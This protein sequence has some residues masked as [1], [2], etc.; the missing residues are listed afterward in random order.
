MGAKDWM[1]VYAG[2]EVRPILRAVPTLDRDATRAL[3]ARLYPDA[4]IVDLG[5]GDLG[6]NANPTGGEVYAG[7]FPGLTI[8]CTPD[9]GLDHPSTLD[10]RFRAEARGRTLYLHAMHSVV[11]WFAYA[12]WAPDGEL[13]RSLSLSPESGILE[14]VGAPLAFEAPYWAGE[15]AVDP[16]DSGYPLPFHPLELAEDALRALFGFTYEGSWLDDD[17]EPE[18]IVLAGFAVRS[19]HG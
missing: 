6:G 1:L 15:R 5:D 11:D 3:V 4:S 8:V 17:P 13:R 19:A 7:C 16:A 10:R 14:N 2:G 18:E 12:V 9:A